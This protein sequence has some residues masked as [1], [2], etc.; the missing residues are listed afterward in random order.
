MRLRYILFLA[1]VVFISCGNRRGTSER[2]A[3]AETPQKPDSVLVYDTLMAYEDSIMAI[4]D[5]AFAAKK[6]V[7]ADELL[8]LRTVHLLDRNL[9]SRIEGHIDPGMRLANR[10]VRMANVAGYEPY[11]E[12]QWAE[13]VR[14]MMEDYGRAHNAGEEKA[15]DDFLEGIDYLACGSQPE[16]NR[17]CY[18]TADME[19]CKALMANN[20]LIDAVYDKRLKA[21]LKY[22]YRTWNELNRARQSVYATRRVETDHYSALPMEIAG[23]WAAYAIRRR[24]DLVD[25]MGIIL[26]GKHYQQQHPEA[27]ASDWDEYIHHRL[28]LP[29]DYTKPTGRNQD[30]LNDA[31]LEYDIAVK[32]WLKARHYVAVYPQGERQL[33]YEN[34]TAD[35]YWILANEALVQPE[36]YD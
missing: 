32:R 36:G 22:E 10:F 31:I 6:R 17:Y 7:T 18:L 25:E 28:F 4:E 5:S 26:R 21:L 15:W 2:K 1:A 24:E 9:L 3:L 19:Y 30:T 35:Y 23:E 34:M 13:A 11:N 12:L 20:A 14:R 8:S 16:I 29:E 33:S 27:T